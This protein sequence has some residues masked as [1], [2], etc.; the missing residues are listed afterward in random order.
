MRQAAQHEVEII[1]QQ[2]GS[3]QQALH[4]HVQKRPQQLQQDKQTVEMRE[5]QNNAQARPMCEHIQQQAENCIAQMSED[6]RRSQLELQEVQKATEGQVAYVARQ[7]ELDRDNRAV[8][9]LQ[10]LGAKLEAAHQQL[11]NSERVASMAGSNCGSPVVGNPFDHPLPNTR[12]AQHTAIMSVG[13][14]ASVASINPLE[15]MFCSCCGSQNVAG[16][17]SCWRCSTLFSSATANNGA[18]QIQIPG[19]RLGATPCPPP[20]LSPW[21]FL[22]FRGAGAASASIECGCRH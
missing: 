2:A 16:R 10:M 6:N 5:Q 22:R 20:S 14:G 4:D 19:N 7:A 1:R 8:K 17:P 18:D 21:K 9:G 11:R 12:S 13:P 15:V 3:N